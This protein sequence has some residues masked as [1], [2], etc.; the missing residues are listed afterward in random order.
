MAKRYEVFVSYRRDNGFETANLIAEKLRRMGYSVFFDVESLR[1]GKFNEQL[2][3]HIEQCT[4]FVVV[5]PENGLDRCVNP[6]DWVR[7]EV[8]HAMTMN[9]N[10]VP[11]MLR[12]F[13]WPNPMPEGMD[14]LKD[15]Q[16]VTA[17]GYET[18]DLSIQR[19]AG[20]LNS[21]PGSRIRSIIKAWGVAIVAILVVLAIVF[22]VLRSLAI[23][24]CT[25]VADKLAMQLGYMDNIVGANNFVKEYWDEFSIEYPK[26]KSFSEQVLTKS[27]INGALDLKEKEFASY[28]KDVEKY[29][30]DLSGFERFLVWLHGINY[31]ELLA[32]N[33]MM[34]S[35]LDEALN[36]VALARHNV[37]MGDVSRLAQESFKVNLQ[38]QIHSLNFC[39]YGYC[40][41]IALMPEKAQENF[42]K[43]DEHFNNTPRA[44]GLHLPQEDYERFVQQEMNA[45]ERLFGSLN[46][47]LIKA[48]DTLAIEEQKYAELVEKVKDVHNSII[49]ATQFVSKD[50]Q[51]DKWGKIRRLTT[52]LS[53]IVADSVESVADDSPVV[54]FPNEVYGELCL[55]LSDYEKAHPESELYVASLKKY[56]EQVTRNKEAGG[57]VLIFAFANSEPHQVFQVGDIIVELNGRPVN[58]LEDLKSI[59]KEFG[60][61]QVKFWRMEGG[62]L[63]RKNSSTMGNTDV[64]GFLDIVL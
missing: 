60:D 15:F 2:Y 30:V 40:A 55:R 7:K 35:A 8:V 50:G 43:M 45:M 37:S 21:K 53:G 19:L 26:A 61:G 23:P 63:V 38:C 48:Q 3:K 29:M 31:A 5:L 58:T 6:D 47:E 44:V 12:N 54:I 27:E 52:Y 4:D 49:Q 14:E 25:Q 22:A 1:S 39:Y 32:S 28:A 13:S 51:W 18:F 17:T 64:L 10:V 56:Y 62:K 34:N 46:T 20:Y 24:V 57:G 9:K 11:V 36:L 41:V 16:A 33:N 59:F 42:L